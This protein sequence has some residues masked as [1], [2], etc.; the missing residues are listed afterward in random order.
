MKR[1]ESLGWGYPPRG[2]CEVLGLPALAVNEL[3]PFLRWQAE[4]QAVIDHGPGRIG[5]AVGTAVFE[6]A[7]HARAPGGWWRP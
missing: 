7:A 3:A 2:A 5:E 6:V 1:V 4:R